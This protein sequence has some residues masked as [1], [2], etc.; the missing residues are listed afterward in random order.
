MFFKKENV[1]DF[2][3][4]SCANCCRNFNV[5]ITHLDIKRVIE[6]RPDLNPSDFVYFTQSDP[7]DDESESFISTYGKRD[8]SL[9]KK[10]N[11]QDCVFLNDK[12]MCSIHDFKPIVCR[13]WPFSLEKGKISWIKEHHSFIKKICKHTSIKGANDPDKLTEVLELHAKERKIYSKLVKIWNDEKQ[14]EADSGE[15]FL[16]ILDEHFLQYILKELNVHKQVEVEAEEEDNFYQK[17]IAYL[18]KD[19]KIELITESKL[20]Q[21]YNHNKRVDLNLYLYLQSQYIDEFFD[22][23]NIENI[24]EFLKTKSITDEKIE[25]NYS[26]H[27]NKKTISFLLDQKIVYLHLKNFD[28]SKKPLFHDT[29]II[30]NPY[31]LNLTIQKFKESKNEALININKTFS[32]KI[33]ETLFAIKNENFIEAKIILNSILQEEIFPLIYWLNKKTFKIKNL[34]KLKYRNEKLEIFIKEALIEPQN[35]DINEKI[36]KLLVIFEELF[37]ASKL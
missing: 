9:K 19:R 6:N 11:S 36:E 3:C 28:E 30:Y 31:G 21:I 20:D 8:I 25:P 14:K 29:K 2:A 33:T 23:N 5:N 4:Q 37:E 15:L 27:I 16:D 17:I 34:S 13:V 1:L 26:I 32:F 24:K 35:V 22:N 7:K 10:P 12:N 18:I